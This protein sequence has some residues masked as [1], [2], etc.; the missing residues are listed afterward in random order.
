MG[1][2]SITSGDTGRTYDLTIA[3]DQITPEE[4]AR[5]TALI[6][7]RDA[8]YREQYAATT[9]QA[10]P[11]Y[12]DGTAFG[13]GWDM[14]KT[15]SY[16]ALGSLVEAIGTVNDWEGLAGIGA[17]MTGAARAEQV[18]ENTYM[19]APTSF[20]DA[21]TFGEYLTAIGE[22]AGQSAPE[23]LATMAGGVAGT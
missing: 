11:D 13:R 18:R 20:A 2:I 21:N 23:M 17:R 1:S 7:Q 4:S 3:G 12:G 10:L 14:G 5:A 19:P 6:Q 8:A 16:S 22:V 15:T 9:G